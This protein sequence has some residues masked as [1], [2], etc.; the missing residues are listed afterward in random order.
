MKTI[1]SKGTANTAYGKV[2]A[3]PISFEYSHREFATLEE[4]PAELQPS[5]KDILSFINQTEKANERAKAQ[6]AAFTAAGI[7]KPTNKDR[8]FALKNIVAAM[9]AQGKSED[10]ARALAET[11]I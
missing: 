3:E 7:E 4:V 11:L 9:V 6:N 1:T 8:D 10:E 5:P 2:L